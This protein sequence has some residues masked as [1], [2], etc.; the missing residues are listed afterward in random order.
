MNPLLLV[1]EGLLLL[2]LIS[3]SA[4]FSGSETVLFSLSPIQMQRIRNRNPVAGAR[5][6]T[7]LSDPSM[8]LSTILVG[9]TLLNF[10]IASLG[11]L[12]IDAL[13]PSWGEALAIPVMTLLLLLFGDVTPKRVAIYHAEK[14]APV[15]SWLLLFWLWLLRPFNLVLTSG[16]RVFKKALR[17]ER[18]ALSND[19]LRT[20]VEVGEEQ[21]VLDAEEA[22]MVDGIMRLSEL[23][24]SDEMT[25]RVDMV[26]LDLDTPLAAQ[27]EV[28]RKSRFRYLPVYVRTPDAIEGFVNTAQFLLGAANDVRKATSPALFVP[29]NVSLDDLLITFQRSGK[30]IACVLDEYG[31]TAG[32]ITRGDIL[33]LIAAPVAK[34]GEV[35][36]PEIRKL[37][38]EVW[39][40][41]GT[42]SLDELNRQLDLALEAD[43]A[44]RIAGWITFHAGRLP[45]AGQSV[46]AQGCRATVRRMLKRR[47]DVI[48]LEVLE[49]HE[50][51]PEPLHEGD[52]AG[53]EGQEEGELQ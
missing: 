27:L 18:R 50:E 35:D 24:A 13:V 22:S 37:G 31:G 6:E 44:D 23:K 9:N 26:G 7:L 53:Y 43:D 41:D 3:L 32:L 29:E 16:S 17:R 25:P 47:I 4:F 45:Q 39:L 12:L 49:R 21:G 46:E 33:D 52:D 20:V 51:V 40:I 2:V 5:L 15:C 28:A 30:H 1:L 42:V 19:E 48:Q 10:A 38:E 34:R 11:Y 14:L 8:I 36:R